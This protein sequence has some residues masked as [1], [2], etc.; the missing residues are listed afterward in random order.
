VS[1]QEVKP[2]QKWASNDIHKLEVTG[3]AKGAKKFESFRPASKCP[4]DDIPLGEDHPDSPSK[5]DN[6]QLR[7]A[8]DE[9]QRGD[10]RILLNID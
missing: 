6:E 7:R 10:P 1:D 8:A 4:G 2:G 9:I 3:P 5:L